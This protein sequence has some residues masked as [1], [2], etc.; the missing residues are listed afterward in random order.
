MNL[1]I[2][3]FV[4]GTYLLILLAVGFIFR[5]FSSNVSDYFR[6]GCKGTWW[7][8]GMSSFMAGISAYTFT[9]AAGVAYEVG[10]SVLLM[11]LANTAGFLIN[12]LFLAPYFRRVRAITM[13]EVIKL[14]FGVT[15][16][17]FFA[18][19]SI[20]VYILQA[21]VQLYA[22]AIFSSAIFG[23]DIGA[24][25]VVLGAAVLIYSTIGGSWAVMAN[26][27]IQGMIMFSVTIVMAVVAL[28]A[29]GGLDGFARMIGEQ[30]L[31]AD[32][33]LVKAPGAFPENKYTW[34]W[35]IAIFMH[36]LL[37]SCS[38][39]G[40]GRYFAVKDE[41]EAKRAA[42]IGMVLSFIGMLFWF[43]PPMVARLL[44]S[45]DVDA[46]QIAKPAEA[47]F[48]V[49]ASKLL[50]NGMMGLMVVAMFA[51]G[52]SSLDS[53][54]NRNAAI[55]SCDIIPAMCRLFRR[56]PIEG[57]PLL[58]ISRVVSLLFGL[59]I[60]A[61]A[62]IFAG[63][64]GTGQF[65]FLLR[66]AS[67]VLLPLVIPMF[68]GLW[69]RRAPSWSA[70][71]SVTA[72]ALCSILQW[73]SESWFGIKINYQTSMFIGTIVSSCA[74]LATALFW[75]KTNPEYH[76]QVDAFFTRLATPID[77]EKEVGEGNDRSQ[78]RLVGSCTA[79][80]GLVV[81]SLL[82]LKNPWSG[83]LCILCVGGPIIAIG[84][85]MC[86]VGNRRPKLTDERT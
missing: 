46:M 53:G 37:N 73:N 25:I 22:L 82:F 41:R 76:R 35:V 31:S 49:A 30:G 42:L 79:I 75:E 2:E 7:M 77:F 74:F 50:P 45:A 67:L 9:A 60:I 16:Q 10:F 86:R 83:R 72:G 28:H 62:L 12:Y 26:D 19:I 47:A 40:A 38:L 80:M 21:G 11:Y 8:V 5:R 39:Q 3:M 18:W 23:F 20:P 27:F 6:N 36:A 51:A 55:F 14:R 15:T 69:I 29:V 24:V 64:K 56:K 43:I 66:I 13:P 85:F 17:Q 65:E 81:L 44:Y 70:M 78:L 52:T 32:F 63:Q 84:G 58:F 1:T 33:S 68:L 61:I 57:K 59:L 4:I 34:F 54:L 71:V 48:A